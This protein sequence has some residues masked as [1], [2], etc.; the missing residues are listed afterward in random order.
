MLRCG[1]PTHFP[2][3]L[4]PHSPHLSLHL[5]LPPPHPN[6]LSSTFCHTSSHI[7]PSS[8]HTPTYFPTPIPTS[9]SPSQSVAKLPCDDVS[10][11]K[12]PQYTYLYSRLTPA[13]TIVTCV[14]KKTS[15]EFMELLVSADA[16]TI[17]K[18]NSFFF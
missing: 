8:P 12:L 14:H 18:I 2:T 13:K 3:S 16:T 7:S 17:S 11:T 15:L 5:P 9:P 1:A 4:S 6:I 10:V